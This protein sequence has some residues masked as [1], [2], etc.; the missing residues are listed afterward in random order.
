MLH[1]VNLKYFRNEYRCRMPFAPTIAVSMLG[2]RCWMILKCGESSE[3]NL[4]KAVFV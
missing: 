4:G 3:L 1:A 2:S